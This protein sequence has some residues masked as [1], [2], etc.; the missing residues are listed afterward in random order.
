[1][2]TIARNINKKITLVALAQFSHKNSLINQAPASFNE[3][4]VE[5]KQNVWRNPDP[6]YQVQSFQQ[7]N[8]PKPIL[9]MQNI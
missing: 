7:R 9:A 3:Q 2:I 6:S 5:L 4:R 1:M 8:R